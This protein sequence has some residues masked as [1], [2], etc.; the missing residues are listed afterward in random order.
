MNEKLRHL[1]LFSGI[2]GFSLGLESTGGF[3][4]VG[5][6]D[7][8]PFAQKVLKK[9][10]PDVPCFGDVRDVGRNTDGLGR[11]DIITG[12]F[13]CQPFSVAGK[14]DPNDNR[15]LWPEMFRIIKEIRPKFVI[16]E[17]VRNLI[18][19]RE[20]MVFEQVCTDLEGEGY[21]VQTYVLPASAV[22][23]PH[24][25]YRCWIVGILADTKSSRH[26]GRSSKECG[27][28]QGKFQQS[29]QRWSEVGSKVKGCSEPHGKQNVAYTKSGNVEAGRKRSGAI[30]KESEGQ[31]ASGDATCGSK[32]STADVADSKSKRMERNRPFRKQKSSI[33]AKK[34]LFTCNSTGG[35]KDNWTVEPSVG[36]V[37]NGIPNRVDRLKG[38][39]NAVVPQIPAVLG[40]AILKVHDG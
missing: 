35:N 28:K 22:N 14:Q 21:Q 6:C 20:G 18:S 8:E 5:F 3:E 9:H 29:K 15:Q 17:N 4:T 7:N 32:V 26:R 27:D 31:R 33:S 36:R 34:R 11:V 16:G 12:G 10:W 38:L 23:A 30:R 24:Q 40:R 1:D 19:I 13:P 25:R 37:A 39:G 2:G